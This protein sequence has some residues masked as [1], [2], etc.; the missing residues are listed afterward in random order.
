VREANIATFISPILGAHDV[1]FFHLNDCFLETFVPLGH[2]LLIWQGA[3]F[4]ELK[5]QAYIFALMNSDTEPIRMLDDL[6]PN[7]LDAQI[8]A[9]HPDA[10]RLSPS[11]QD[12]IDCCQSRRSY[13][14]RR[15]L[16]AFNR[17]IDIT[18]AVIVAQK[19]ASGFGDSRSV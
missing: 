3:V 2:R 6:L 18:F 7:D 4:L 14:V 1:S 13:L 9:R 12:F 11:E 17:R 8:L 16:L 10:P 15:T 19:F 5:T